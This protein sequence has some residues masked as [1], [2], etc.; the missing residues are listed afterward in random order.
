MR[1]VLVVAIGLLAALMV[2]ALLSA[3][4]EEAIQGI[5]CIALTVPVGMIIG[6]Y[7]ARRVRQG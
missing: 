7:L 1:T 4:D 3:T 6:A 5:R 2:V